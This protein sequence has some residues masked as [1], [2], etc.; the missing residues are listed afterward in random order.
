[1]KPF[2]K[3]SFFIIH[4]LLYYGWIREESIVEQTHTIR[5]RYVRENGTRGSGVIQ[6][7]FPFLSK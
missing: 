5:L 4:V 3:E 2:T 1:M 7:G 6:T